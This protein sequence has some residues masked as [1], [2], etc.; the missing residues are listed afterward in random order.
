MKKLTLPIYNQLG[1]KTDEVLDLDPAIFAGKI[2]PPLVS[3][4]VISQNSNQRMATR[5]TKDRSEVRGGGR[6]P[7]K[8]K[9][10]GR[11]RHGSIRSPLWKGGGVTFG[12]RKDRNFS[13]KINKKMRKAAL[14]SILT[15]KFN[16]DKIKVLNKV[17]LD[18]AKTKEAAKLLAAF[19]LEKK[20]I[21]ALFK[22]SQGLKRAVNNLPNLFLFESRN[23]NPRDLMT[24]D[25]LLISKKGIE[26]LSQI[27]L[28]S[29]KPKES[30][31]NSKEK[32]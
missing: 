23:L 3:Q 4:V 20:S 25:F 21:L 10:T 1:K 14:I 6:K 28:G 8:Q 26:N 30:Y 31:G 13:K 12:P 17:V 32:D 27:I 29:S 15:D 9:G 18:R 16:N 7:W 11:A 2:N 24:S 5:H 19:K 22:I